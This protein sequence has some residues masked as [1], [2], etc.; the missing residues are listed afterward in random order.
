[1]TVVII[2][3]GQAGLATSHELTR[4]GVE[5]V[6]L[7]R[8]RVG[9]AWRDRW[10]SFCLVTPNWTIRL[11]GGG[12][13]GE[14]PDG[15]LPRDAIVEHLEGYARAFAA[16]VRE[17]VEVTSL[18]P[19][20]DG[21]FLLRT[22]RGDLR[23]T[24]VVVATGAYQRPHRPP[25]AATLPGDVLQLDAEGYRDPDGLPDGPVLVVGSG[26][27]GCQLAEE[28]HEAGREVFLSCGRALWVP[29]RVGGRD[30]VWWLMETGFFDQPASAVAMPAARLASNPLTTGHEGGYDLHL[31]TLRAAGVTL[32]GRFR[33]AD[34]RRV[35]FAPDLGE[36]V[37]WGDERFRELMGLVRR[38]AERRG[39]PMPEIAEPEPFDG[40]APE[41][42]DLTGFAAVL[43]TGGFRPDYGRWVHVPGAFDEAGFPLH[44]DG[45]SLAAPG[46]SFVGVHFLRTRKSSLLC[47]VGEDAAV[48]AARI[49]GR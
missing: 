24:A 39:L 28:L 14:D 36:S 30:I 19:Q 18:E 9:Q 42:L 48:V 34:G 21:G 5:H 20:Q 4:L 44:V 12:Y 41:E 37:R 16:P 49:A 10:D 7:E 23:A 31:R 29:R 1:M 33:G 6:V 13:R 43:F 32:L 3:A 8:A 11:P 17:G 25:G 27:T 35:R 45:E 2:G 15:Y 47:G 46:L 26:Q 40:A 38:L 22:S